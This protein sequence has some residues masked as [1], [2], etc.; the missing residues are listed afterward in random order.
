MF[1]DDDILIEE[2][3]LNNC[4]PY[5]TLL[6]ELAR[7]GIKKPLLRG[8]AQPYDTLTKIKV[9]ER[10]KPMSMDQ[11]DHQISNAWFKEKFNVAARTET[12]FVTTSRGL[13]SNYGLIHYV[14]P[15]G[16]FSIINSNK[17]TDLFLEM[18]W[19]QKANIYK[20]K[21]GVPEGY[22]LETYKGDKKFLETYKGVKK[23]LEDVKTENPSKYKEIVTTILENGDYEKNNF[24][25]AFR[26]GNEIMLKCNAFYIISEEDDRIKDFINDFIWDDIFI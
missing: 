26:N 18:G 16:K 21:F 6:K 25:E 8:S 19:M 2:I 4:K 22:D 12:V 3:L 15:I 20:K 24:K 17:Y 1:D 7:N 14:F 10:P 9:S 13:A 11:E 23:F 5:L